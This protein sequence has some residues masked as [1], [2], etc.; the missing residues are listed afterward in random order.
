M[1]ASALLLSLV[2]VCHNRY[3]FGFILLPYLKKRKEKRGE[4]KEKSKIMQLFIVSIVVKSVTFS[5][6]FHTDQKGKK[7]TKVKLVK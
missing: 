3:Q 6:F 1:P 7:H 5:H 2:S 4:K